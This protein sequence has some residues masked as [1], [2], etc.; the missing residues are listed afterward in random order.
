MGPQSDY[1]SCY[2]E[3]RSLIH[4]QDRLLCDWALGQANKRK[5]NRNV[6][7]LDG[8]A[9]LFGLAYKFSGSL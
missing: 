6:S 7:W 5:K 8:Q 2:A 1:W 9:Y 3:G 4:T